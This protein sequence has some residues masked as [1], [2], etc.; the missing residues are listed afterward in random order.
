[1][2]F[3]PLLP[4][5]DFAFHQAEREIVTSLRP[6]ALESARLQPTQL[7]HSQL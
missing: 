6:K 4:P 1:M 3:L 5:S 2:L 7:Y